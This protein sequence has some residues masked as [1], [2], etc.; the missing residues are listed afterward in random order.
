MPFFASAI[1]YKLL[2]GEVVPRSKNLVCIK[3]MYIFFR[4]VLIVKSIK[5][6][7]RFVHRNK[8]DSIVL[9]VYRRRVIW[10]ALEDDEGKIAGKSFSRLGAV[11]GWFNV[12][13]EF[14]FE[15]KLIFVWNGFLLVL[16]TELVS[17]MTGFDMLGTVVSFIFSA[18]VWSIHLFCWFA[19]LN[20]VNTISKGIIL[21]YSFG[22][23]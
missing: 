16:L 20:L 6:F 1:E 15:F 3:L 2:E 17:R 22:F 21:W 14:G 12:W 8:T 11:S 7:H 19:T 18:I 13:H 9:C 23:Y 5:S 10:F 4:N